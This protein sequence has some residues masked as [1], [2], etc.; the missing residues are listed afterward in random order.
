[1]TSQALRV[2]VFVVLAA[3]LGASLAGCNL[4]QQE[5]W[6]HDAAK[7]NG[8]A[9]NINPNTG[10]TAGQFSIT[11]H[12]APQYA[13]KNGTTQ[14]SVAN[15]CGGVDVP[16]TLDDLNVKA[17]ATA[18][19]TPVNVAGGATA[20]IGS[21]AISIATGD[22]SADGCAALIAAAALTAH[23]AETIGTAL[24]HTVLPNAPASSQVEDEQPASSA[25]A[26]S[27]ASGASASATK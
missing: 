19:S 15:G 16:N 10:V 22:L 21:P 7:A 13:P 23:P 17:T 3:L 27:T 18:T 24:N 8:V 2:V 6:T 5:S 11:I 20:S 14:N 26:S 12:R 1:M 9:L 4:M 25:G